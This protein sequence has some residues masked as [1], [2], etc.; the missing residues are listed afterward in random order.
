MNDKLLSIVTVCFNSEKTIE[1]TIK[2]VLNQ[3]FTNYEYIF[4]DGASNDRTNEIIN[5]YKIKFKNKDI[6]VKHIS[7]KDNGIYD[8]M[9]KG[10]KFASGK[11]IN[12]MNSDDYFYSED[13]LKNVFEDK[14]ILNYDVIYGNTCFIKENKKYIEKGKDIES[15]IKHIPFCPQSS[16][17]KTNLQNEYGF[18]CKYKISADF[19][20]FLRLYIDKK[21]FIYIDKI[22]SNFSFG[23]VSNSNLLI[24]YREDLEVKHSNKIINKHSISTKIKYIVFNLRYRIMSNK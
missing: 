13:V 19:D 15:I 10:A 5:K 2:S 7:E 6:P 20:F 16:F 8:A 22:V 17:V 18:N 4:I 1:R 3:T 21:I 9:N 24:T 11:W 12:Y 14:D 23:G